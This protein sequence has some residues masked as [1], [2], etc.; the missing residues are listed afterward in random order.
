MTTP[1]NNI[2]LIPTY[3]YASPRYHT[4][5]NLPTNII[6]EDYISHDTVQGTYDMYFPL[7]VMTSNNPPSIQLIDN[8]NNINQILGA[9]APYLNTA[10]YTTRQ[11]GYHNKILTNPT[12]SNL[13][14]ANISYDEYLHISINPCWCT[15]QANI[16]NNNNN[17]TSN[18]NPQF[19]VRILGNAPLISSIYAITLASN[20]LSVSTVPFPVG[21]IVNYN[22][23]LWMCTASTN[24]YPPTM[25]NIT[26]TDNWINLNSLTNVFNADVFAINENITTYYKHVTDDS[27]TFNPLLQDDSLVAWN[28]SY[29]EG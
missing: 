26:I 8:N 14:T 4:I 22:N 24:I 28:V 13:D 7:Y 21:M 5:L 20:S 12:N 1:L 15:I 23:N 2:S 17:N 11:I 27:R 25:N 9:L 10:A 3:T 29:W 16:S 18:I 19:L 6:P